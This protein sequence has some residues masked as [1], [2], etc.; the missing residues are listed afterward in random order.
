MENPGHN[1]F[2]SSGPSNLNS[3]SSIFDPQS[4]ILDL[5]SSLNSSFAA[6]VPAGST[7]T[8]ADRSIPAPTLESS[9]IPE[10][11]QLPPATNRRTFLGLGA[12]IAGP[13]K[14]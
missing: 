5:L 3:Q 6:P 11:E 13:T 8:I 2:A 12:A 9:V 14:N 1:E 4:S 10:I 7:P